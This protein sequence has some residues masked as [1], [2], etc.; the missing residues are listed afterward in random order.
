M[1]SPSTY[2]LDAVRFSVA[3]GAAM[4]ERVCVTWHQASPDE[5][6]QGDVARVGVC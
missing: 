4:G 3:E 6:E 5:Y 2:I 1:P